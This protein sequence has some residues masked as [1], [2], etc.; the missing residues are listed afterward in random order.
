MAAPD[1]DDLE[2]LESP[3][4]G[5]QTEPSRRRPTPAAWYIC[6]LCQLVKV[7]AT[8]G[9][10]VIRAHLVDRHRTAEVTVERRAATLGLVIAKH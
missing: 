7:P 6:P 10:A 8:G 2:G 1:P 3:F 9:D 5:G 4:Y